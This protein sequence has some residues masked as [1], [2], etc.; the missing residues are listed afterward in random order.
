MQFNHAQLTENTITGLSSNPTDLQRESI[1]ILSTDDDGT[2][3]YKN[4]VTKN[5]VI[6][7]QMLTGTWSESTKEWNNVTWGEPLTT[8]KISVP[9]Q[10]TSAEVIQSIEDLKIDL[11]IAGVI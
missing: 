9:D 4:N 11:V 7:W 5:V 3:E 8:E 2:I 1:I 10:P 6:G